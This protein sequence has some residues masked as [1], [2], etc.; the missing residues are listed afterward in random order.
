MMTRVAIIITRRD[1]KSCDGEAS[2]REPKEAMAPD[3]LLT[4]DM[5]IY[6]ETG[7]ASQ[8]LFKALAPLNRSEKLPYLDNVYRVPLQYPRD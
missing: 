1:V 7:E 4:R 8:L 5:V 6:F 3:G 2:K